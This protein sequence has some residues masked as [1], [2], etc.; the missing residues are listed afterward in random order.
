MHVEQVLKYC[1]VAEL[2]WVVWAII[3]ASISPVDF[4][5]LNYATERY[6]KGYKYYKGLYNAD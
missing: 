3:Q 6:E 4:D 1:A 5:Y 2:R